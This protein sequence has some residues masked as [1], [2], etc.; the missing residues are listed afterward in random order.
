MQNSPT[1]AVTPP[2]S[3]DAES[4]ES[5]APSVCATKRYVMSANGNVSVRGATVSR[6]SGAALEPS[7]PTDQSNCEQSG[8]YAQS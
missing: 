2:A 7:Q 4:A 5:G 1:S 6:V 8:T 3:N